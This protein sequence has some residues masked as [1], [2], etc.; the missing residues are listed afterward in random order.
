M[1]SLFFANNRPLSR[2]TFLRGAGVALSLPMLDAMI[3]ALA[4][5][6]ATP[7]PRRMIAIQTTMGI[8][9][10]YFFP[11]GTGKNYK[12]SPYLEILKAYR[13]DMTVFSGVSH[14]GVD[15]GHQAER[16]FLTAA[17]HPGSGAFKNTISLDQFAAERIGSATRFP[18]LV[19]QVGIE[20]RSLS[21]TRAGVM[22]PS[23][24][25]PT[26]L[27]RKMF[28]QGTA[29]Q[30]EA[31][32][33]DLRVGR[34]TLDFVN[35]SARALQKSLGPKDRDRLDQYFTSVRDLEAQLAKTAAWE[36][37]PKPIIK[38]PEPRDAEKGQLATASKL[39]YDIVR[40]ALET[41]STR[42]VTIFVHTLGVA[43]DIPGVTHETHSLTHHGNR[44]EVLAELRLIEE[45]QFKILAGLLAS[46]RSAKE[47]GE[48]LLDRTMVL[49]GTCLGSANAHSNVNM[50]VLLAGGGF[51]HAGH[52]AFDTKKNYPLAKLFVSMLQR[53]GLE[54]ERFASGT[55][56]M[57]G[58]ELV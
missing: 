49:Y 27:Y 58:L 16:S 44:P 7:I 39:M 51:K 55:G 31:R 19:T 42:L 53:L 21:F 1:S 17:P 20:N 23:E 6:K 48:T 36:R 9:P 38:V 22:I 56:T 43:T 41:D 47:G 57:R 35:D 10:Q 13:S 11:E 14:P 30:V 34:S 15:G 28:V 26:S 46:L 54:A 45:K 18:A 8:L 50:P 25:S 3:P 24:K 12:P 4:R 37:K 33:E 32:L 29:K 52:L 5:G 2:R 40:L